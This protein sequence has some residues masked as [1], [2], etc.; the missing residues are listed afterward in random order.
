MEI[1]STSFKWNSILLTSLEHLLITIDN[2]HEPTVVVIHE[3]GINGLH[4]MDSLND[5]VI[6]DPYSWSLVFSEYVG[7]VENTKNNT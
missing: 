5:S 2:I 7:V 6:P 1:P 4:C 3:A